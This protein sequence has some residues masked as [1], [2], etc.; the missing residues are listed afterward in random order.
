MQRLHE[1][2]LSGHLLGKPG[3]L[4][5][6]LS[7]PAIAPERTV[8]HIGALKKI[9]QAG[10]IL[11]SGR[12]GK[13]QLE[14]ARLEMGNHAFS[15]QYQQSPIPAEGALLKIEWFK[16]YHGEPWKNE[17]N[18]RIIQSWDTAIKTGVHNDYSVCLTWVESIS[19]YYL[20]DILRRKMEYPE[21]KKSVLL[22]SEQWHPALLLIEDKASGQSLLQDIRR[23]TTLPAIAL[24][25]SQD[26]ITRFAACTALFEAGKVHLPQS[27]HFLAAYETE[28]LAF[29]NGAHDDMVDATSQF[30]GYMRERKKDMVR[31]RKI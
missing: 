2:D 21:L 17:K 29:P 31:I 22:L 20:L 8:L 9:R 10:N 13:K 5:H 6:H 16:Y 1:N 28:L 19:G 12:E 3:K 14:Q 24:R 25:P 27:A 23:E 30:L 11:H 7:L 15:A 4:W 18:S 26:K